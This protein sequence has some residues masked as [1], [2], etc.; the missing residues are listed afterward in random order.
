[1]DEQNREAPSKVE[2]N[3]RVREEYW[4][5]KLGRIRIGVEP[6]DIQVERFRRVTWMLTAIP[7]GLATMF[8]ALF[9]AF[10]RP[11]VGAILAGVLLLPIVLVAWIDFA[12]LS[13]RAARYQ[14]ELAEHQQ[15]MGRDVEVRGRT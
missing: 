7:L 10:G 6:I 5:R 15:A 14:R 3:W 1:M 2:S 11:D 8:I 4:R 9:T 12:R 13:R